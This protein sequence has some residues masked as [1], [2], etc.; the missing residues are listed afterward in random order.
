MDWRGAAK[1]PAI[2]PA[3]GTPLREQLAE[4]RSNVSRYVQPEKMAPVE[5]AIDEL[6]SSGI[7]QRILPV[8]ARAPQFELPDQRGIIIR[9]ED[10]LTRGPLIV[11]F[12][13]GRWCPYCVAA[14]E[15]WQ[16]RLPQVESAGASIV[17]ISPQKPQHTFFTADQH[18]L[19][20]PVL[21]DAHN[22]VARQFGLV[23]RL[24]DYLQQHYSRI[25]V[26]LPNSN[27]DQSWEL[28]LAATYVI[29]R[30]GIVRYAW[31]TADFRE[32]AEPDDV[33][34]ALRS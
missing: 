2:E 20:Y 5:R 29:G 33:L 10:L 13:R 1:G 25:F 26:N 15:E 22:D 12:F 23:Y 6:R 18:H 9:S 3:P 17:A 4:I 8:G 21:S 31:A 32:R 28:P 14:L 34:A 24:P 7:A 11:N 16:R 30:D 27:A 19:R